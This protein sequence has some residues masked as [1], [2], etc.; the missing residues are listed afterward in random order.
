MSGPLDLLDAAVEDRLERAAMPEWTE[1][2]LATLTHDHFSSPDWIYERKLDGERC[3]VL[4][5]GDGVRLYTRNRKPL[6]ETY[7]ELIAPLARA[8]DVPYVADGEIVAFDGAVTSFRRLQQR[9]GI[10]DAERARASAVPVYLY[11]FD[12]VYLD[13]ARLDQLP[14]RARKSLL[15]RGL[16]LRDPVRYTPHRNADGEAY[17]DE[18]CA[19]GW[20]GLIAKRADSTYAH[21]RSRDWLKFKCGHRQELVIGGYTEPEGSRTGFGALLVGYYQDDALRYAGKVGTGFDEQTLQTLH[22][23]MRGLEREEPAFS[24]GGPLPSS[25]VHWTE[26]RLVAEVGFTEWTG[27]GRLRHPRYLGL[28]TDKKPTDVVR[29]D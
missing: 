24:G 11:L 6:D 2:M 23:R 9:I 15:R 21:S 3:L 16:K 10:H 19:K 12:L 27:A 5:D 8:T 17:L 14:L 4:R 7:P 18:A 13:D 20:E 25:D 26:P 29:E 1:P 28:R 22:E